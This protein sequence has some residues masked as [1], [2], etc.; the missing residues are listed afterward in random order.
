MVEYYH[1]V[2][3]SPFVT[4]TGM[5]ESLVCQID[6]GAKD[7]TVADADFIEHVTTYWFNAFS[8]YSGTYPVSSGTIMGTQASDKACDVAIDV[9]IRLKALSGD[10]TTETRELHLN[11]ACATAVLC[12]SE[13][14]PGAT[15]FRSLS[16]PNGPPII[17]MQTSSLRRFL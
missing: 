14:S 12:H 2:P 16:A 17:K 10:I 8:P 9:V 1:E 6:P 15:L 7:F 13:H 3:E 4:D 11:D 5:S